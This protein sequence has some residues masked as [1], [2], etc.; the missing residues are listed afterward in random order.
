MDFKKIFF[1]CLLLLR[2]NSF[3]RPRFY[4]EKKPQLSASSVGR[5][6]P[7][8]S[9]YVLTHMRY[10]LCATVFGQILNWLEMMTAGPDPHPAFVI[11]AFK[12]WVEMSLTR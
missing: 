11:Q 5:D 8:T 1:N 10:T 3:S 4:K 12:I 7:T 9:Y 2:F 6:I